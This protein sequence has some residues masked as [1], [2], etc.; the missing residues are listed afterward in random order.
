[1]ASNCYLLTASRHAVLVDPS[2]P[3]GSVLDALRAEDAVLDSILLTHG[4]FDHVFS[5]SALREAT[6]ARVLVHER[7]FD[8]PDDPSKNGFRTFFGMDRSFGV[9]DGTL[10]SGDEIAVG[11]ES[12]RVLHTPGHTAGSVCYLLDGQFLLT[13]DTLFA[14]GCGR[15]D[16]Y[17]GDDEQIAASLQRLR[18]LPSSL[19]IYPGHG[20]SAILGNALD[21]VLYY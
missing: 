2:A 10:R 1:M 16:L 21:N 19:T 18:A 15:T 8:L 13:G 12:L 6:G 20:E 4:H 14:D 11:E 5:L 17:S 9:P 7:D 3:V